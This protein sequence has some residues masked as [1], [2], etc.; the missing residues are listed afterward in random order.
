MVINLAMYHLRTV[1]ALHRLRSFTLAAEDMQISQPAVSRALAEVERRIGGRLFDRSTRSVVPTNLGDEISAHA[2]MAVGAYDEALSRISRHMNGDDGVV[3]LACLPS[4]T[5]ALLP[6]VISDFRRDLPQVGL[7][8]HDEPQ[9]KV[10]E[11]ILNGTVDLGILA[12]D[13]TIPPELEAEEV[14]SDR[15]VAIVPEGHPFARCDELIW[16]DF[17]RENFIAFDSVTSIGPL[18][19][20]AFAKHDVAVETVQSARSIPAVGGL[21]SA[22]LGVSVVPEMVVPLVK[23]EG[24]ESVPITPPIE[25][26][27]V[28]VHRKRGPLPAVVE[29]FRQRLL[30]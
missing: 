5:A 30:T 6:A 4:V 24:I 12:I 10:A 9:E 15:L 2:A 28:V 29:R 16:N 14:T 21:V 25:R 27:L 20:H 3:R 17:A 22:G 1:E 7:K 11:K 23:F 19:G 18:V 13:S 8:I 26:V